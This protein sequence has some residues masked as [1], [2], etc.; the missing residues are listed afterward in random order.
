[1]KEDL[2]TSKNIITDFTSSEENNEINLKETSIKINGF[3]IIE[4]NEDEEDYQSALNLD[5][6]EINNLKVFFY[7]EN[8]IIHLYKKSYKDI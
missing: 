1:M 5:D 4:L 8:I 7:L 6:E 3:N 2:N